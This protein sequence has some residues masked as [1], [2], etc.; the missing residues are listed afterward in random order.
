MMEDAVLIRKTL[1]GE[2]SAFEELVNRYEKQVYNLCLRMVNNR[3]DAAD[4][5]QE[6]FLKAWRGLQFFKAE[7]A[8]STWMYRLTTNVCIDFL[9]SRKRHD[10]ISLTVEDEE[11]GEQEL[12]VPDEAP[13]PEEQVLYSAQKEEISRAMAE[14]DEESRMILTLR[15][16][17]DLSYEQI[18]DVLDLKPGTVKSRLARARIKLKKLLEEKGNKTEAKPSKRKERGVDVRDM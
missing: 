13:L 14:L 18:A 15:V 1:Q 11:H 17:E 16:V 3:E 8:F 5:T 10:S 7:A 2:M 6:A 12:D 4:L 9:R